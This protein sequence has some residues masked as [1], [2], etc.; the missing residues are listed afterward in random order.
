MDADGV[1]DGFREVGGE[2]AFLCAGEGGGA[3]DE[4][5]MVAGD[6]A[7]DGEGDEMG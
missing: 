5:A 1:E 2:A 4:A 3:F 6:V 7:G